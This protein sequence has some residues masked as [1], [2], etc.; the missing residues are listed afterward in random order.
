MLMMMD[1]YSDESREPGLHP[2]R[3]IDLEP[4]DNGERYDHGSCGIVKMIVRCLG[5]NWNP[6]TELSDTDSKMTG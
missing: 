5:L 1:R 4:A 3:T 2:E 6:R